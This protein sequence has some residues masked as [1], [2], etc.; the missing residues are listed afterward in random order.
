MI[1]FH[2]IYVHNFSDRT[3][4][5]VFGYRLV[6][7]IA[8]LLREMPT[9]NYNRI[10]GTVPRNSQSYASHHQLPNVGGEIKGIGPVWGLK[11]KKS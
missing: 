7:I 6:V 4:G 1:G 10:T 5:A 8:I 3:V 11:V 2:E 9:V